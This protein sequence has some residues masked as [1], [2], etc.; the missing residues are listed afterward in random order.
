MSLPGRRQTLS[1]EGAI[2]GHLGRR[3]TSSRVPTPVWWSDRP[4]Q[5]LCRVLFKEQR[6][7]EAP[8]F[9][10][11]RHHSRV[12]GLDLYT[13]FGLAHDDIARQQHSNL[14]IDVQSLAGEVR[15]VGADDDITP[16]LFADL[17]S[18]GRLDIDLGENPKAL[19][20]QRLLDLRQHLGEWLR[21]HEV[22]SKIMG[23]ASSLYSIPKP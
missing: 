10:Q 4:T 8:S 5:A 19:G 13:R 17:G 16:H 2:V 1:T 6:L 11:H 9:D 23:T 20:R 3:G 18:E 22:S 12:H 14:C 15:V 7:D 21:Q